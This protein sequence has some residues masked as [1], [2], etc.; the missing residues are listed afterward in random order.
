M[1][2]IQGFYTGY[3]RLWKREETFSV[4]Q[5]SVTLEIC[6]KF[7]WQSDCTPPHTTPHFQRDQIFTPQDF[8]PLCRKRNTEIHHFSVVMKIYG[9]RCIYGCS[10]SV[11]ARETCKSEYVMGVHREIPRT[12]SKVIP[13][14][15]YTYGLTSQAKRC[16]L[17]PEDFIFPFWLTSGVYTAPLARQQSVGRSSSY[18]TFSR[19]GTGMFLQAA[20]RC[21]WKQ[22][23][24]SP[25]SLS[26]SL[27]RGPVT[28]GTCHN[29]Q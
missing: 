7:P 19:C 8:C 22:G 9:V 1:N 20:H 3:L 6:R 14:L 16:K 13:Y 17:F 24:T 26:C 11:P 25:H 18:R 4:W 2:H 15:K 28:S 21:R 5:T 10:E 27:P 12:H 23:L 29:S